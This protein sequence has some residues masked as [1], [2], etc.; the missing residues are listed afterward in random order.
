MVEPPDDAFDDVFEL[1]A[2]RTGWVEV[3]VV[4][5]VVEEC[6]DAPWLEAAAVVVGAASA[7]PPVTAALTPRAEKA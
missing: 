7:N 5:D 4:L 6:V 3:G 2:C 1:V